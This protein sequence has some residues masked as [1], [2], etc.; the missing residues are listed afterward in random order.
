MGTTLKPV[1]LKKRTKRATT[2]NSKTQNYIKIRNKQKNYNLIG[3]WR[4]TVKLKLL[5][6][7][8]FSSRNIKQ[9]NRQTYKQTKGFSIINRL[10]C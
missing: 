8:D 10:V 5:P 2:K 3:Y 9:T 6:I 4:K 7:A 1:E